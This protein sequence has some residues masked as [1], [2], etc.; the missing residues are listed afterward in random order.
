[1]AIDGHIFVY[2]SSLIN[3]IGRLLR[4]TANNVNQIAKRVNSGGEAYRNDI[5]EVN[6]Q[7]TD[8]RIVFGKL[9]SALTDVVNAKPG[10]RFIPPPKIN[11]QSAADNND[12]N[13]VSDDTA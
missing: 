7:L 10:K 13:N 6:G 12:L 5:V 11:I 8:L 4:I 2:D 9:L 3:E 1:M